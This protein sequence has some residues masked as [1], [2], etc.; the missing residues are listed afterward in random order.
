[1]AQ[2][3][4][5]DLGGS[6]KLLLALTNTIAVD[7]TLSNTDLLALTYSLRH[8]RGA[9][10]SFLTAPVAGFGY[11]GSQDVVYLDTDLCEQLWGYLNDDTLAAH[12]GEFSAESLS[13]VPR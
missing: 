12:I 4:L 3:L 11:E 6:D 10:L 8:I 9:G 13:D 2:D 7:D 1:M 5:S